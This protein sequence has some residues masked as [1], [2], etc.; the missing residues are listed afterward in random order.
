MIK[1]CIGDHTSGG[2]KSPYGSPPSS[3]EP[4]KSVTVRALTTTT[5]LLMQC[6]FTCHMEA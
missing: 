2:F 6:C 4:I 5:T 3:T 1:I